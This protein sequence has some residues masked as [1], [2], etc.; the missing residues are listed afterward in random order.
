MKLLKKRANV[1]VDTS[2]SAWVGYDDDHIYTMGFVHEKLKQPQF[3][4]FK[5]PQTTL[6]LKCV[7]MLS[8]CCCMCAFV[9]AVLPF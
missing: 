2:I 7:C 9:A 8:Y 6:E 4:M 1:P 5:V 3:H